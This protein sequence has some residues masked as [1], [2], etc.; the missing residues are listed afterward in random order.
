[1]NNNITEALEKC[2][3]ITENPDLNLQTYGEKLNALLERF[4]EGRFQLAVLGQ[5]KRGKSTLVNALLNANILPTAVVPLTA[6]PTFIYYGKLLS[7]K[8]CFLNKN[9]DVVEFTGE[10]ENLK[11]F[12]DKYVTE[13]GNPENK[14]G[15]SHVEIFYPSE[16]LKK[17]FVLIDTPGIGS[18]FQH[19]TEM[20]INFLPQCDAALFVTSTD[21]PITEVEVNFLKSVKSHVPKIFFI[22]NKIDYL[23]S[24][25]L[26]TSVN[27][28]KN[29]LIKEVKLE[30]TPD[31]FGVS[32]K[33]ALKA[34]TKQDEKSYKESN[35]K[36][37]ENAICQFM[38]KEKNETLGKAISQKA[39][40]I[41]ENISMQLKI[42]IK[43]Y[44]T[45]IEELE[46][47]IKILEKKIEDA[48]QQ[49]IVVGDILKGD[50]KRVEAYLDSEADKL[51]DKAFNYFE[52]ELKKIIESSDVN[53]MKQNVQKFL[54]EQIP[55]YFEREF[56]K[57]SRD[58]SK[59]ASE[60]LSS[61]EDKAVEVIE[62]I[63]QNAMK[64]MDIP[65][66]PLHGE[67]GLRMRLKPYWV[68]N[69]WDTT[70]TAISNT[71]IDMVVGKKFLKK[72]LVKRFLEKLEILIYSNIENLRWPIYQGVQDTFRKFSF[73]FDNQMEEVIKATKG[74]V[75]KAI[76]KKR[77]ESGKV[78]EE[79]E[80]L[81]KISEE[82]ETIKK[83]LKF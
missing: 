70:L 33:K 42:L 23:D 51:K 44:T 83:S 20:T 53:G 24:D 54:D 65:Y 77:S 39:F 62:S 55:P 67:K 3:R 30:N 10:I 46:A 19:N 29:I 80:K 11:E 7:V 8:V 34:K 59:K 21:P 79:L 36:E 22:L 56:G 16:L 63:R 27:F 25:E 60:I 15:V 40:N 82:V 4:I 50:M 81:K 74:V 35:F 75:E 14:L 17:G 38:E 12:L 76:E 28:L 18:T 6:I 31:I 73:D 45:P 41:M 2:I 71:I 57:F 43:S 58:F 69:R 66:I 26:E 49:K 48:L 47:K 72:R 68:V 78:T 1:M 37:L 13:T 64:L 5:F 9:R 32:S 61:H 52:S